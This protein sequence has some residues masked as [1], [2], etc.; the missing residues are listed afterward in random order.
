MKIPATDVRIGDHIRTSD[1][2]EVT[3]ARIE[4]N[5]LGWQGL[6]AFVEDSPER[7]MKA[8]AAADEDVELLARKEN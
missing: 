5:M 2:V 3:V 8:A 4:P 6:F 7:W 1:G